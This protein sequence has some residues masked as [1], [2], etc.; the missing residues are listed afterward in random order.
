MQSDMKIVEFDWME[1]ATYIAIFPHLT[2]PLGRCKT[3]SWRSK[4]WN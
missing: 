1:G 2:G 4:T 3:K